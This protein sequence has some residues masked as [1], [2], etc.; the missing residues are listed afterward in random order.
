MSS[1]CYIVKPP[2]DSPLINGRLNE[3]A[4]YPARTLVFFTVLITDYK[5]L[6]S[7]LSLSLTCLANIQLYKNEQKRE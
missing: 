1:L 7:S 5:R 2:L 4:K 3:S 6:S